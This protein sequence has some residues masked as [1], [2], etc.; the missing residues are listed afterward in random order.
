MKP[1]SLSDNGLESTSLILNEVG[2]T[3]SLEVGAVGRCGGGEARVSTRA[4]PL[5]RSPRAPRSP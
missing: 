2:S 3:P 4:V 5:G 1:F